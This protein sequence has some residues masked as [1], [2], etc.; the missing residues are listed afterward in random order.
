MQLVAPVRVA[1]QEVDPSAMKKGRP[2]IGPAD[3]EGL[4]AT[5]IGL[6]VALGVPLPGDLFDLE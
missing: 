6:G 5:V 2:E 1:K 4:L 3:A